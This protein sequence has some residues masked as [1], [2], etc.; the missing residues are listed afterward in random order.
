MNCELID[1]KVQFTTLNKNNIKR[2]KI[3]TFQ[4]NLDTSKDR[5]TNI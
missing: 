4:S 1:Q 3:K 5:G 2:V